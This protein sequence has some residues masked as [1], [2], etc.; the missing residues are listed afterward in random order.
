VAPEETVQLD[1][2]GSYD[3][4]CA[5]FSYS[6][7]GPEDITLNDPN[8]AIPSFTAPSYSETT[9]LTFTLTVTDDQGSSDSDIT[10]IT[11]FVEQGLT[12][13]EARA[14]GVGEIV[15]VQGIVTTPIFRA[16]IPSM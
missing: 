15:T 9:L 6:W 7:D 4:E 3:P 8:S 14:L 16:A 1:G 13:A 10:E 12:I 11:V 2:S 5:E